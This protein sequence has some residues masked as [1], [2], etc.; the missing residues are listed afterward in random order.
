MRKLLYLVIAGPGFLA[1][2]AHLLP[3]LVCNCR[4]R[5]ADFFCHFFNTR[6][7]E[8]A[9]NTSIY[10]LRCFIAEGPRW[11]IALC[12]LPTRCLS[13]RIVDASF[14][15]RTWLIHTLA[16]SEGINYP[17]GGKHCPHVLDVRSAVGSMKMESAQTGFKSPFRL[18]AASCQPINEVIMRLTRLGYCLR[19]RA[20]CLPM[21]ID[22]RNTKGFK[23]EQCCRSWKFITPSYVE[24]HADLVKAGDRP[25]ACHA[26]TSSG[27]ESCPGV[28]R[29][30]RN[31][32][33][34]S[35]K[36]LGIYCFCATY[37]GRDNLPEVR[38]ARP[39]T[40]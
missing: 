1:S 27:S 35:T 10:D 24:N 7:L 2:R 14:I 29:Q 23:G 26:E 31:Y 36:R 11:W 32:R 18:I 6:C 22:L 39:T 19:R 20:L 30:S 12:S 40:P 38:D 37:H 3:P 15:T 13:L 9:F 5:L 34:A 21:A 17:R 8:N 33:K 25:T 4:T 16:E 28:F